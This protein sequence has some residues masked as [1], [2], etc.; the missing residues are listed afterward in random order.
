MNHVRPARVLLAL[1]A[2]AAAAGISP[3]AG[4]ATIAGKITNVDVHTRTLTVADASAKKEVT[5]LVNDDSV[6][7][8]DGDDEAGLDDLYE[9]DTVQ[10]ATVRDLGGGRLLLIKAIVESR[11]EAGDDDQETSVTME[12]AAFP[13]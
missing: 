8:L 2:V 7:V 5:M 3:G 12:A 9:G 13:D 4:R 11:P 1:L 10:A 6:I